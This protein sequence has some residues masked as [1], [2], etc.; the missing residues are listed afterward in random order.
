[1]KRLLILPIM[2][3][4]VMAGACDARQ[5]DDAAAGI[6]SA[7][8]GSGAT[9]TTSAAGDARAWARCMRQHGQN[10]PDQP[11]TDPNSAT[12]APP[13]GADGAAWRSAL[14]ACRA[15]ES[16]GADLPERPAPMDTATLE[17]LR[18]FAVCMRAHGLEMTDPDPQTGNMRIGGR[19]NDFNR[20]QAE[21]DPTYK[22]A[23]DACKD[24]LPDE[25][26]K[27]GARR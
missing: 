1:M 23:L 14:S 8:G 2:F 15:F 21:Q 19:F 27:K 9:S 13:D 4:T 10:V 16:T 5:S 20:A 22:A 11:D 3:V 25:T 12:G 18:E 17:K 6:A 24:K 26:S 7:T